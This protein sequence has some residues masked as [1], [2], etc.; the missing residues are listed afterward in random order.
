MSNN[1]VTNIFLAIR[2]KLSTTVSRI[3]PPDQ[4]EDIVQETYVRVCQ[5]EKKQTISYPKTFMFKTARNLALDF[6]KR[7]ESVKTTQVEDEEAFNAIVAWDDDPYDRASSNHDFAMFCQAVRQLPVKTRRVYVLKK[8][9]GYSQKEIAERLKIAESTVE[10]HISIGAKRC[11]KYMSQF[12]DYDM[13][14]RKNN[15]KSSNKGS[16]KTFNVSKDGER[17]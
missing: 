2:G 11:A 14:V 1:K 6:I 7:A 13:K 3:V 5:F 9:Y 16:V 10:K 15:S 4:I 17:S 12:T 8:V